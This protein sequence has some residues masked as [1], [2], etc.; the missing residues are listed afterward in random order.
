M[1]KGQLIFGIPEIKIKR[2]SQRDKWEKIAAYIRACYDCENDAQTSA[3]ADTVRKEMFNWLEKNY[4]VSW[5]PKTVKELKKG[6][7]K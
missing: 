1:S 5:N 4:Q 6:E 7:T 3:E 2:T